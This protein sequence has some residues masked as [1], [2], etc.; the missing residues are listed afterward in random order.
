MRFHTIKGWTESN[1]YQL[2]GENEEEMEENF[3]TQVREWIEDDITK[4]KYVMFEIERQI[5]HSEKMLSYGYLSQVLK[6]KQVTHE[7]MIED[8]KKVLSFIKKEFNIELTDIDRSPFLQELKCG[9]KLVSFS[10]SKNVPN[11]K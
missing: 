9:R 8:N 6:P 1:I 3:R 4:L 10:N 7:E 11:N 2:K 5:E